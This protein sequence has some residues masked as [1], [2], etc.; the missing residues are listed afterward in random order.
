MNGSQQSDTHTSTELTVQ[1]KSFDYRYS[2]A[3]GLGKANVAQTE[4]GVKALK[5]PALCVSQNEL[6][7]L[8]G[9]SGCGKTTMLNLIAGFL[10]PP[11]GHVT[12]LNQD[13]G[14]LRRVQQN[15]QS[16]QNHW[17]MHTIGIVPQE[18]L[19]I[20][21]LNAWQ[22]A[23]LPSQLAGFGQPD[24]AERVEQLFARLAIDS[25]R[26][27]LPSQ[28]SRGQQQRVAIA[29]AFANQPRLILADEPTANLDD[30]NVHN[31]MTLIQQ[32]VAEQGACAIV[33]SHD[34]RIAPYC[35]S[36]MGFNDA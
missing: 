22:N 4:A 14:Q 26:L 34:A 33:A 6:V 2:G 35:T 10:T 16:N 13:M 1:L 19:L 18:P 15:Q 30:A 32:L 31:V 7:W 20:D 23:V 8:H 3:V 28:L 12:V 29:R 17:R 11:P 24:F 21:S 25:V 5:I 36:R 27:H 9:P